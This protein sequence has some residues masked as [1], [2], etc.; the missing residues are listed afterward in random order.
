MP[1]PSGRGF[2]KHSVNEWIEGSPLPNTE[3]T[4]TP[5][6]APDG[7]YE[8]MA[9]GSIGRHWEPR[10]KYAGTYDQDWL[11]NVFPFLPR[12]FDEQYYQSGPPDQQVPKPVGEQAV[13]LVNLTRSGR[14]DFVLPHFEASIHVF[15]RDETRED[16]VATVDTILIE[17]D[18][19]RVT[20]T[21]RVARP[22]R[23]NIFEIAHVLVGR[24]GRDWWQQREANAFPFPVVV[25]AIP[26]PVVTEETDE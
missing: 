13:T 24:K 22:L 16:L 23:R 6:N 2:H 20:M 5:V 1:N 9:F 8:P 10:F 21:W 15:T 3:E 19:S 26:R 7:A 11:D 4:G 14:T 17:P 12:D 25:E 18:E